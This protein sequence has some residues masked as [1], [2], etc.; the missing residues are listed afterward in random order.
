MSSG[1]VMH[2]NLN[3]CSGCHACSVSCKAEHRAPLG[4]FRHR[5]QVIEQGTFPHTSRAFVPTLCQHCEEAPCLEACG[6]QAIQRTEEGIVRIDSAA[7][8]GSGTCVETCPYG[9]IYLDPITN[10]ADKCDFC[11][12]RLEVGEQPAC[13]ST[14]PTDAIRFGRE[15]EEGY[16]QW[17][18]QPTR[19]RVWYQGLTPELQ[20]Q[21]GKLNGTKE[22]A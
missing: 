2:I 22:E 16:I 3:S 19:P 5:I 11:I 1:Y 12:D 4:S 18:P 9:A 10:Q 14:C 17:E 15:I 21:L 6:V 8:I 13:V 20:R 7:C